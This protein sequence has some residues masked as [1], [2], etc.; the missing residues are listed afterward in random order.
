MVGKKAGKCRGEFKFTSIIQEEHRS[1][2][3]C[4][5][6]N[7]C[8]LRYKDFFAT[9]G[10][11]RVTVYELLPESKIEVVQ[12]YIDDNVS[13]PRQTLCAYFAD[14]GGVAFAGKFAMLLILS[15]RFDLRT[16]CLK[17]RIVRQRYC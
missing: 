1:P 12:C 8:D 17:R 16:T 5:D 4:L 15:V 10:S 14:L 13:F 11:N 9:V 2:I 7:T 3:Y 6:F